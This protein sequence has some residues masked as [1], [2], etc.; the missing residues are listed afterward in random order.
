MDIEVLQARIDDALERSGLREQQRR[1]MTAKPRGSRRHGPVA[2]GTVWRC[3]RCGRRG[4]M[5]VCPRCGEKMVAV[6][7][8]ARLHPSQRVS[9]GVIVVAQE[10][11]DA[12]GRDE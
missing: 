2:Q 12:A 1:T 5:E 9:H 3:V 11:H 10:A 6:Y 8:V 4:L 7:P